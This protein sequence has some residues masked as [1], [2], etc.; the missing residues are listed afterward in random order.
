MF[1][2]E[3]TGRLGA[4]LSI[5]RHANDTNCQC[6]RIKK[7][8]K[9]NTGVC[10]KCKMP[11]AGPTFHPTCTTS[12]MTLEVDGRLTTV[13][14]L[15]GMLSCPLC[16]AKFINGSHLT[17]SPSPPTS[18]LIYNLNNTGSLQ[19]VHTRRRHRASNQ[20]YEYNATCN[21]SPCFASSAHSVY[22]GSS[23]FSTVLGANGA[24]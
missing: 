14:R 24:I 8:K 23:T 1:P 20:N 19:E 10:T 13:F 5:S 6:F 17:A 3:P 9:Q 12:K 22:T 7:A 2:K 4:P 11:T 15:N 18:K 21:Q 16:S